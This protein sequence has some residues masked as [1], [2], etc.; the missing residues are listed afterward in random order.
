V[1][2]HQDVTQAV[3]ASFACIFQYNEMRME[4]MKLFYVLFQVQAIIANVCITERTLKD[5][6]HHDKV[7]VS[8]RHNAA[9]E[10]S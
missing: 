3:I 6:E 5:T 9:G 10:L 7:P 2:Y 8:C 4:V 1:H